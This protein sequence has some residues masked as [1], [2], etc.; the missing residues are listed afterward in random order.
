VSEG[1]GL[2]TIVTERHSATQKEAGILA[3]KAGVDVGISIEDAYMGGLI[4]NVNEGK[5]SIKDVDRAVARLLR[6]KFQMGLFENPYVDVDY[7]VKTVHTKES[8]ELALQTSRE[9]IVLLKNE[10]NALPLKKDIK[11]IAVIGPVA[12]A[13]IDQL[14]DY[15]PHYIP[16]EVVT[17]LGGVELLVEIRSMKLKRQKKRLKIQMLR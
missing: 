14:G 7:A 13:P 15:I 12:D 9:S 10:K 5:I 2:G 4:E 8:K 6:L 3:I 1:G 16:Q 17:V 11:S